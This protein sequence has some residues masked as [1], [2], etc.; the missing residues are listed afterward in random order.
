[1]THTRLNFSDERIDEICEGSAS[2]TEQERIFLILD[3]PDFEECGCSATELAGMSDADLMRACR[4]V[5]TQYARNI[6]L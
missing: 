4:R 1:M 6:G 2:L 3:T 5:W